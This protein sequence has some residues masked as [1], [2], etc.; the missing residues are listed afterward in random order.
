MRIL[1]LTQSTI[2]PN[3]YRVELVFE[4]DGS[5]RQTATVEF[6]FAL[7]PQD[8]ESLRWYLEDYLQHAADPAPQIAARIERRIG[9]IGDQLFQQVFESSKTAERL[10][11]RLQEHLNETR[12]EIVAEVQKATAIPWELLRDP[13]TET[14]LAL[15]ANAFVRTQTDMARIPKLPQLSM[16]EDKSVEPIRILLV[17]CRPCGSDD[18]PFRSVASRLIKGLNESSRDAY[19]LDVLRPPTFARLG[20]VLRTAKA[21]GKPYHVVHFDG[22]GKYA[23]AKQAG[24][25]SAILCDLGS[26]T[27]SI[28]RAGA[29]G[30]LLFENPSV[31]GNAQLV[32]GL[33][34]GKLLAETDVPVLVLN[35]CRSAHA[36]APATPEMTL[37]QAD[38]TD[39]A[40]H[41]SAHQDT[42]MQVRAFGSLAQEVVN[43]G[44][45]GVVAMRYNVYVVTAAQFVFDL[46]ESLVGG[47]T[48][49]EAVT[50]GRK[51]LE[52]QPLREIAYRPRPLQDW[53][54]P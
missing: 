24:E 5:P 50:L 17:I 23:E 31:E 29:H 45:G 22:H 49:G 41:E 38:S 4:C 25:L 6:D 7:T 32:D 19:Q 9:E 54:V 14:H 44:V 2:S 52:T 36:E 42:H 16:M 51:Q 33:A 34:L 8:R 39:A 12:I 48:L 26:L 37:E 28:P 13:V 1:R 11:A 18:V 10:W 15:E 43:A 3:K 46:Y 20:K 21:E 53:M 30:Y 35:A 47:Q 40:Q 27:L